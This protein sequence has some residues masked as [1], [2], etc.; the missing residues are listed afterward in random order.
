MKKSNVFYYNRRGSEISSLGN[1]AELEDISEPAPNTNV[2]GSGIENYSDTSDVGS[3]SSTPG[4]ATRTSRRFEQ[5]VDSTAWLQPE[6][7]PSFVDGKFVRPKGNA[8][9]E[10]Y[11]WSSRRGKHLS[12]SLARRR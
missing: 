11:V 7:P 4:I 5:V 9:I 6:I 12:P 2:G 8:P 3:R 1:E 10:G